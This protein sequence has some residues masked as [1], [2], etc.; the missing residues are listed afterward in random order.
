MRK[1]RGIYLVAQYFMK[2]RPGVN[3]SKKG[4]MDDG[5][6]VRYD[7]QMTVTRGLKNKDRDAKVILNLSTKTIEKNAWNTERTFDEYFRYYLQGYSQ[8]L[9]PV[10]TD[11]D[12]DYMKAIED[13]IKQA[14]EAQIAESDNQVVDVTHEEVETK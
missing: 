13:E 6:N 4:W 5:A 14:M 2:P 3:T 8:Y 9:V 11:L 1:E 7:E 10:M 12:P